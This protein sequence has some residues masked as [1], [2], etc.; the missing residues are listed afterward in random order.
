MSVI[1]DAKTAK[2]VATRFHVPVNAEGSE[3]STTLLELF[4]AV[5]ERRVYG[6]CD[7]TVDAGDGVLQGRVIRENLVA[8]EVAEGDMKLKRPGSS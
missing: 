3:R 6:V 1:P 5:V 8:E 4:R 2:D 7:G